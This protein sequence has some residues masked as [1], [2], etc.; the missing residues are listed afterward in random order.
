ML[1][2]QKLSIIIPLLS[3]KG[4][5]SVMKV[6]FIVPFLFRYRR[7]IE[8]SSTNLANALVKAGHQVTIIAWKEKGGLEAATPFAKGLTH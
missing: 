7:G 4:E 2:L 8:R 3:R 5:S 1:L 6:C